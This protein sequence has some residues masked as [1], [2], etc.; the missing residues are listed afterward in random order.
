MRVVCTRLPLLPDGTTQ[1]DSPW[2]TEQA[3]Y[4]VVSLLAEPDGGVQLHLVTDDP[5][6][7]GWFD[8][9]NFKTV[10]AS[11]PRSWAVTVSEEG[12][13]EFAPASWLIPGFWEAYYEGDSSAK[14]AVEAELS[15]L[16]SPTSSSRDH[17]ARAKSSADPTDADRVSVHEDAEPTEPNR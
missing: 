6:S 2:L 4:V 12:V 17:S 8:S 15:L 11:V 1:L 7:L 9:R 5:M 14:Q 3:E 10:E 13:V 16:L